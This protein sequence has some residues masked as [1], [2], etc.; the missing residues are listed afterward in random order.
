MIFGALGKNNV[1]FQVDEST[2][3][4]IAGLSRKVAGRWATHDVYGK[5]PLLQ[6]G[7]PG[8]DEISFQ[9]RFDARH[10]VNPRKEIDNLTMM[11][12][13]GKAYRMTIG[14][15]PFGAS[16]MWVISSLS[17]NFTQIDNKGRV[18]LAT[19]DISLQEYVVKP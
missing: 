12:S 10:G 1:I 19:A 15:K 5:K 7:G 17:A 18:L 3:R 9:M 4:T 13:G 8:L 11:A 14:G 16:G 6:W 2:I